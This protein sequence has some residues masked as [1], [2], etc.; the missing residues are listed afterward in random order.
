MHEMVVWTI[1]YPEDTYGHTP[2][3]IAREEFFP[4]LRSLFCNVQHPYEYNA[5]I[6]TMTVEA[7]RQMRSLLQLHR[8]VASSPYHY[9]PHY[10]VR[11]YLVGDPTESRYL[12]LAQSANSGPLESFRQESRIGPFPYQGELVWQRR[13]I[14][15]SYRWERAAGTRA[16]VLH[17]GDS[18][19][20]IKV[21]TYAVMQALMAEGLS[22]V[23]FVRIRPAKW[24]TLDAN[25][26][27]AD[28]MVHAGTRY[29]IK[30]F[31]LFDPLPDSQSCF[32]FA[33]SALMPPQHP[34]LTRYDTTVLNGMP[35]KVVTDHSYRGPMMAFVKTKLFSP[36]IWAPDTLAG[37]RHSGVMRTW[38]HFGHSEL[39]AL[40]VVDHSGRD[41]MSKYLLD[42]IWEPVGV[43]P[44]GSAL[45]KEGE[46]L[47]WE[48]L[49]EKE[50][51][52]VQAAQNGDR[53]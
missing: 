31:E 18:S 22:G 51:L 24:K 16:N 29:G 12:Y 34:E 6:R 45:L 19:G 23:D 26:P 15:E 38:E 20:Y 14:N 10:S 2:T 1:R 48:K 44:L 11:R 53:S 35:R 39:T 28:F 37:V 52:A 36:P 41:V 7:T 33:P 30:D 5:E 25:W 43:A 21:A 3:L 8:I 42:P 13:Y 17:F 40:L 27:G 32:A 47:Y 49:E 46:E 50:K 4:A 9:N